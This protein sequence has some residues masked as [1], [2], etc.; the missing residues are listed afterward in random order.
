MDV[1]HFGQA[2]DAPF[3]LHATVGVDVCDNGTAVA[4]FAEAQRFRVPGVRVAISIDRNMVVTQ[5]G[6]VEAHALELAR[7][8]GR[9][10]DFVSALP[11]KAAPLGSVEEGDMD[12]ASIHSERTQKIIGV[13]RG[14]MGGTPERKSVGQFDGL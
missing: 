1:V 12:A 6:V 8:E 11:R 2:N 14:T 9:M 5:E 3:T 10:W 4:F 13:C 7:F